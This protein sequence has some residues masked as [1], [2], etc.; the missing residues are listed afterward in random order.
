M[1]QSMHGGKFLQLNEG[2][3]WESLES[4]SENSQHWN[5]LDSKDRKSQPPKRGGMYEVR[6]DTDMR[7]ALAS[8]TRKVEA[9]TL[10]QTLNPSPNTKNEACAL[11][12]SSSHN[13]QS[14]PSIPIYQEALTEQVNVLQSYGKSSDS[15]FAP[16]Y[17]PNW[18]NHPNFSWRQNQPPMNQ[19]GQQFVPS[20]P[21]PVAP[22][23]V[24][25][26][27]APPLP[28]QRR[29]SLEENLQQFMQ[30]TQQALQSNTQAISK[31]ETQLGEMAK[32]L[33]EREKGKLPSQTI[34][35]PKSQYEVGSSSN[36]NEE[37]KA[38]T[39]LRSGKVIDNQVHMPNLK[40]RVKIQNLK[41]MTQ[42]KVNQWLMFQKLHTRKDLCQ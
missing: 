12:A 13:A 37:V 39:T 18:R 31:L 42:M 26:F 40:K 28:P 20:N 11:C 22:Q 29:I 27:G 14:C 8:L 21:Y 7:V 1:I 16:T 3:A 41:I 6:D 32:A 24:P 15:P 25:H 36:P 19:G 34:P 38:I 10:S 33:G 17:N 2:K 23:H 4:L 5:C 9:L 35:N 30:S